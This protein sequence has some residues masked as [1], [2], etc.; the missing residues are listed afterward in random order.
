MDVSRVIAELRE[1][2]ARLQEVIISLE[3]LSQTRT[4]RR[5]RLPTWSKVASVTPHRSWNGQNGSLNGT[6]LSAPQA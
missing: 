5:G 3:K 2:R 6:D 1:E 4:P